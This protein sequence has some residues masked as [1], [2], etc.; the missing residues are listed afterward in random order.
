MLA[1]LDLVPEPPH[2]PRGIQRRL[3][4]RDRGPSMAVACFMP[5]A[6]PTIIHLLRVTGI[7]LQA[8]KAKRSCGRQRSQTSGA[9][10][11]ER[12]AAPQPEE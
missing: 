12:A 4:T 1:Q 11:I 10:N 8:Q 3:A 7:N 9:K 2:A 6:L 5:G